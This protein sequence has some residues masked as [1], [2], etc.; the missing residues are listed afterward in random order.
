MPSVPGK[1]GRHYSS[2]TRSFP[3]RGFLEGPANLLLD[4]FWFVGAVL[5]PALREARLLRHRVIRMIRVGTIG[6]R[7]LSLLQALRR[8]LRVAGPHTNGTKASRVV[9]AYTHTKDSSCRG[10]WHTH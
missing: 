9:R 8:P 4:L 2:G 3:D 10:S 7:G 1:Q 6:I 5:T